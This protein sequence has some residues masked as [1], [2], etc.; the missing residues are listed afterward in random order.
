MK[1]YLINSL[2]K[3]RILNQKSKK[4]DDLLIGIHSIVSCTYVLVWYVNR[5]QEKGLIR[6]QFSKG[7]VISVGYKKYSSYFVLRFVIR[8][9][10]IE[11]YFCYYSST[12]ISVIV[13]RLLSDLFKK[14]SLKFL[15]K[16]KNKNSKMILIEI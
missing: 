7:I 13:I 5:E 8:D 14:N 16:K 4:K 9:I 2:D 12:N 6:F 15:R 1:N 10:A 3:I 11:Q